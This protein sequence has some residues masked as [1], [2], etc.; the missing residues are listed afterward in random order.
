M[1]NNNNCY[2]IKQWNVIKKKIYIFPFIFEY[3]H[4]GQIPFFF[5]ILIF[6]LLATNLNDYFFIIIFLS[7]ERISMKNIL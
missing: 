3:E 1:A 6:R 2:K 5:L 7:W 4:E